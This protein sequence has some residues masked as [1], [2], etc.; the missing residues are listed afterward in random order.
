MHNDFGRGKSAL[1]TNIKKNATRVIRPYNSVNENM[2][3]RGLG[4]T[5]VPHRN[6]EL[7]IFG[8]YKRSDANI[9]TSEI[10]YEDEEV[11]ASSLQISGFH[12]TESEIE[13]KKS[14]RELS[15][16]SRL[17]FKNKH[18]Y[19]AVNFYTLGLSKPLI[20]TDDLYNKYRFSGD[21]L[22]NASFDYSQLWKNILF[23]R[24]IQE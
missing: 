14:I 7:S 20:R 5:F 17:A 10:D 18:G 22:T 16:G 8:S 24:I 1:I 19:T 12:R 6:I 21:R 2:Y 15:I 4:A 9:E 11:Y 13:G 23:W 3:L